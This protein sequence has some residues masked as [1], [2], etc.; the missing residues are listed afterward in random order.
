M[1]VGNNVQIDQSPYLNAN[2]ALTRI[3]SGLQLNSAADDPSSLAISANL[4]AQSSGLS[5]SVDNA[6]SAI[7]SSQIADGAI[8]EQ[9]SILDTVKEKLLQASTDTTSDEGRD[10]L[11][12]EIKDLLQNFDDIGSGTN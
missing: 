5:Q 2:Q 8:R 10:A 1:Q 4:K 6:N 11:L 12:T 7:A 9:S 3:S